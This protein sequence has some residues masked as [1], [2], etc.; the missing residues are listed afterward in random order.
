LSSATDK[1]KAYNELLT[2]VYN[3]LKIIATKQLKY[4]DENHT[5]SRIDLVHVVFLN[6]V[7]KNE[8]DW[9]NRATFYG[10]AAIC[11]K[12]LLIDYTRRKLRQ[13]RSGDYIKKPISMR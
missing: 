1:K 13:K 12:Q 3:Q 2:A 7:D 11:M 9:K 10:V 6:M 8:V 5:Y 4:E